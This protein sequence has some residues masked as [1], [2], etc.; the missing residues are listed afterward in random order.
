MLIENYDNYCII[1][2]L[3]KK[4]NNN[5][6][7]RLEA[8]IDELKTSKIGLN[9]DEIRDCTFDFFNFLK[10]TTLNISLF[11]I[12][13]DIFAVLNMMN[14]TSCVHLYTS[15]EDFEN[16]KRQLINRKFRI[17]K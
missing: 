17:V 13:S 9:L 2:P 5:E 1:T 10:N 14:L 16:S 4:L 3:C 6:M 12:P 15:Q 8:K 11:N 7:Q